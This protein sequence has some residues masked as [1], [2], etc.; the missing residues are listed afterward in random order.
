MN[1]VLKRSIWIL[2]PVGA[3]AAVLYRPAQEHLEREQHID[4][5]NF[6]APDS[7][8]HDAYAE[9]LQELYDYP[10]YR[11]ATSGAT[12]PLAVH[13]LTHQFAMEGLGRLTDDQLERY[14][15][16]RRAIWE[17]ASVELCAAYTRGDPRA[18]D[19]LQNARALEALSPEQIREYFELEAAA[20]KAEITDSQPRVKL[21]EDELA[22][23]GSAFY[24]AMAP[25][26]RDRF[27]VAME[28]IN[29]ISDDEA[30]WAGRLYNAVP[31]RSEPPE[32]SAVLRMLVQ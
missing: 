32:R 24:A 18:D 2:V 9:F 27:L 10:E 7:P 11:R 26:E 15:A 14:M 5:A 25:D 16:I 1:K 12:T 3:L 19:I 23:A 6:Y 30:C 13:R 4:Q 8:A 29:E 21:P 22:A 31:F 20:A 28:D 17:H